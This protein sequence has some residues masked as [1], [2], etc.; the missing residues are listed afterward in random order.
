[1]VLTIRL[2]GSSKLR[3]LIHHLH[4]FHSTNVSSKVS[5]L[6]E[7]AKHPLNRADHDE[8][9]LRFWFKLTHCGDCKPP[10]DSAS[11]DSHVI[12]VVKCEQVGVRSQLRKIHQIRQTYH[13]IT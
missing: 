8:V 12:V 5:A 6:S 10:N 13:I 1:M 9:A 7:V 11:S 4:Q 3:H 2:L